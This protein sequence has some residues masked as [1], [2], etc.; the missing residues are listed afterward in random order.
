MVSTGCKAPGSSKYIDRL[1]Y[2]WNTW[3]FLDMILVSKDL[4]PSQASTKDWFADLG[5][6]STLVVNREQ[7]KTDDKD[8]GFIEPRR[9]DPESHRGVS[10]HF[11]VGIRLLR[12]R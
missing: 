7:V 8:L 11:P 9:F 1:M 6:F 10:D 2:F 12:R 3:S 4:S 5:S